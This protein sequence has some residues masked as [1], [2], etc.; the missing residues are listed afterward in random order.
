MVAAIKAVQEG[1]TVSKAARDHDVPK[2]TLYDRVSGRVTHGNKPGPRPY[3]TGE[4]EQEPGTYLKHCSKVGYGKTRRDVLAIVQNVAADI[5]V[6]RQSQVSSGWWRRFLE[7][8]KDLSLRQGD[9]TAHVRMDAMNRETMRD[10]FTLL[11]DT[12]ETHDLVSRP[13]QIYNV[14]ESG[15][16]FNP[17]PPKVVSEKGRQ[18]KKVRYRCSGRKGQITIVACANAA[19][20]A[21]PPMVI[22]NASKLN[23]AWTKGEIPGTQY[24]LSANCWINSDLFEAWFIEHFISNS[25]SAR[26]LFLL[27][28]GHSTHY[29]PQVIRFA[30]EHECIILCLP[31]HTTHESQ[32]LDVGVFAPLKMHWSKVCHDFYHK[33]PGKVITNFN[34]SSLFSEAWCRAVTPVNI[35][36]GFRRAGVYPLNPQA[37]AIT[38]QSDRSHSDHSPST[39]SVES[40]MADS[41]GE[42]VASGQQSM[43]SPESAPPDVRGVVTGPSFTE[44]QN[45]H[46]RT[47]YEESFDVADDRDYNNWLCLHHPDFPLLKAS[48]NQVEVAEVGTELSDVS[49]AQHFSDVAQLQDVSMGNSPNSPAPVPQTSQ[50]TPSTSRTPASAL[51]IPSTPA[52]TLQTPSNSRTP[53]SASSTSPIPAT[54]L[55]STTST[56]FPKYLSPPQLQSTP[57]GKTKELPRARLLTSAKAV[58]LML[59]KERKSKK[60]LR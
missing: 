17:R 11:K 19:G 35:M 59:E 36:A 10:Y 34:F 48:E 42:S 44:E 57:S 46:F 41:P 2:T 20:Q 1:C 39:Q 54:T 30:M 25:V 6:L 51:K 33:N 50:G 38:E 27:L 21:I 56:S 47:R 26:P 40:T 55:Q 23:P 29:Q 14:D 4:E 18:T 12:L 15:V 37:V 58:E 7:R 16:P 53:A 24:G 31:P 49:I 9:S 13:A 8:Q 52:S 3:L 45:R 28:D 32:P 5:G 43:T 22:F 60:K